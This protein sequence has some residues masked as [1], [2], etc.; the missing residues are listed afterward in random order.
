[1]ILFFFPKNY[2][3]HTRYI[4]SKFYLI[5]LYLFH[6]KIIGFHLRFFFTKI[7][8]FKKIDIF[9]NKRIFIF[10]SFFF[11]FLKKPYHLIHNLF[12]LIDPLIIFL[13]HKLL[14]KLYPW[15]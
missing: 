3:K 4:Q 7:L 8:F 14:S 13:F 15:V 9:L 12:L 6:F 10:Y 5:N 2:T 11:Y 1:M